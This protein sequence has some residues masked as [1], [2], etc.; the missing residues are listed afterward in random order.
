MKRLF[1]IVSSIVL[2]GGAGC[3]SHHS[4]GATAS[5]TPAIPAFAAQFGTD[6]P[7]AVRARVQT[8]LQQAEPSLTILDAA[9][10]TAPENTTVLAFGNAPIATG[11]ISTAD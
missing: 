9:L 5:P 11:V 1:G 3:R 6:L 4:G 7:Q 8:L 2:I 10:A